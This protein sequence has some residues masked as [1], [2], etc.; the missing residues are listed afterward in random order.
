MQ[1]RLST[2]LVTSIVLVQAI[3]LGALVWNSARQFNSSHAELL[4]THT[5]EKSKLLATTLAPALAANDRA[6][7]LDILS[8]LED[9]PYLTYIAVYNHSD[10]LMGHVGD[11]KTLYNPLNSTNINDNSYQSAQ[12]DGIYDLE[13]KVFISGQHIGTIYAGYTIKQIEKLGTKT[14]IENATIATIAILISTLLSLGLGLFLTRNL[15][16]LEEGA[17][18]LKDG[19]LS[20]RINLHSQ[21]EIADVSNSFNMMAQHLEDT[22]QSLLKQHLTLEKESRRMETL[23]NNINAVIFEAKPDKRHFTYVS[24]EAEN[25]LGFESGDWLNEDFWYNHV[26][27]D[28]SNWL[29]HV[30][31]QQITDQGDFSMDFRMLHRSGDYLWI[32]S[33]HNIEVENGKLITRGLLIDINDQKK[34]EERIIYLADHDALTGLYNRRRFQEELE[35]QI[36]YSQR[37]NQSGALLFIDLDQFKYINDTMGHQAGDECLLSVT[38]SLSTTL[39]NIDIM[40]RLGGDEFGVILPHTTLD[41]AVI[42]AQHL[43]DQLENR[44]PFQEE[45]TTH[46]S[47]SIGITI[48]TE[49]GSTPSELLAKADAAMYAAKRKGRSQYHTYMHDDETLLQMHAK[50]HWEDK[51]HRALSED[52]FTLHYQPIF[53][54]KTMEIIHY[55]ALLRLEDQDGSLIYPHAFLDTAEHFGLIRD[56]DKWVLRSAVAMQA[57]S[58]QSGNP[59]SIAINLSGRNFGHSDILHHLTE[60]LDEFQAD[61]QALIFEVTETAAVE[62]FGRARSFIESLRSLGCRFALDDFG[63]GY[64]SFHY[65]RNLPV[66]MIKIDG[67]FVRNLHLNQFDRIIIKAIADVAEGLAILT[68]AEFVENEEIRELLIELGIEFGQGYQLAM[69]MESS[70]PSA[71][72]SIR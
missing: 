47:A 9:S 15:R 56:I 69:P 71:M 21:D 25:L 35:H 62:N 5:E 70:T 59:I 43:L 20:Y 12:S 63:V 40:G 32:R 29:D 1:L 51:I 55:E 50:V 26:H 53:N 23:L 28:D 72:V 4:K 68:I 49:H 61:P 54:L 67:S 17:K 48:F 39:R 8:L 52:R 13:R 38:R 34:T 11:S 46:I 7:V 33:I 31:Q 37:F 3:M 64:S 58:I 65:L 22:Q 45:L 41:E 16:K 19:N 44:A 36:A 66:D 14:R 6:M 60:A 42:V 24:Q 18:A 30:I 27:P 57:E 2:K 10:V